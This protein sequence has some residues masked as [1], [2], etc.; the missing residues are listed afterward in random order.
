MMYSID[1]LK[2]AIDVMKKNMDGANEAAKEYE[3]I[4]KRLQAQLKERGG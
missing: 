1:D 2:T 3:N 4:Y